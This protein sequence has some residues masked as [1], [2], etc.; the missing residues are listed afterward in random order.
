ML[1][2]IHEHTPT[3]K[4]SGSTLEPFRQVA[5][6]NRGDIGEEFIFRYL[7]N[8]GI[9]VGKGASR[10]E[11]WDLEVSVASSSRSRRRPKTVVARSSSIT[12]G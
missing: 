4:W 10:I 9:A 8:S 2:V 11:E 7:V 12:S 3:S 1:E 6:T 5:N